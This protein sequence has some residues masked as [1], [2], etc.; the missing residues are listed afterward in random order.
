MLGFVI[1]VSEAL[2]TSCLQTQYTVYCPLTL[3]FIIS[4]S[5]DKTASCIYR[6]TKPLICKITLFRVHVSL[7]NI[8]LN[9]PSLCSAVLF[10]WKLTLSQF[11][12]VMGRDRG[13]LRTVTAGLRTGKEADTVSGV[14]ASQAL[15]GLLWLAESVSCVDQSAADICAATRFSWDTDNR[16]QQSASARETEGVCGLTLIPQINKMQIITLFQLVS[17]SLLVLAANAEVYFKEQF[18][19]GGEWIVELACHAWFVGHNIKCDIKL[20]YRRNN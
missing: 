1:V 13:S 14:L 17:A 11:C 3:Q 2:S 12:P 6:E 8:S 5:T 10:S 18:L 20:G 7:W 9:R 4:K 15:R 19:D 16:E